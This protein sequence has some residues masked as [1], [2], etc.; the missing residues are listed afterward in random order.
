MEEPLDDIKSMDI[1]SIQ[2]NIK[3]ISSS[4]GGLDFDE[5]YNAALNQLQELFDAQIM[6]AANLEEDDEKEDTTE[7][8]FIFVTGNVPEADSS[9]LDLMQ[10]YCDTDENK[11]YTTFL[12]IGD[13][14]ASSK[15]TASICKMRGCN[16]RNYESSTFSEDFERVL[17]PV[18]FNVH[19]AVNGLATDTIYGFHNSMK[20]INKLSQ[21]GSV[22]TVKT[23]Y[24]EGQMEDEVVTIRLQPEEDEDEDI[25]FEVE[26]KYEGRDGK[27]LDMEWRMELGK[28][29]EGQEDE[30]GY[31]DHQ[32]VRKRIAL[33]KWTELLSE[34]AAKDRKDDGSSHLD[35]SPEY[36]Q[37]FQ[38]F[39]TWFEA[40]RKAIGDDKMLRE[41]EIM[42]SLIDFDEEK[43]AKSR[44]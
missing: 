44:G 42:Q 36:R 34:W 41:V 14:P 30:H 21:Q 3:Q 31:F 39:M 11:I 16:I 6:A 43:A 35:V 17:H 24:L 33:I 10:V 4:S 5:G 1:A 9:L 32:D 15:L 26:L 27:N 18:F 40:Q 37:K 28:I 20:R 22:R 12:N 38:K 8:R 25:G 2:S 7:N 29:K 13:E 23:V 19:L